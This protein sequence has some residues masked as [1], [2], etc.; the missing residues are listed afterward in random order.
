CDMDVYDVGVYDVVIVGGG[1]AGSTLA[2]HLSARSTL[3]VLLV[4]GRSRRNCCGGMLSAEGQA[5]VRE[6]GLELPDSVRMD[7]QPFCVHTYDYDN[8]LQRRYPRPYL[9]IDRECFDRW[10][11]D[12]IPKRGGFEFWEHTL[13]KGFALSEQGDLLVR[14]MRRENQAN[15]DADRRAQR[16][17]EPGAVCDAL[18]SIEVRTRFLVGADGSSSTVGRVLRA[19]MPKPEETPYYIAI[20]EWFQAEHQPTH[21]FGAIFDRS[22]S[23]YY[24]WTVPKGDQLIVGAALE[25]RPVGSESYEARFQRLLQHLRDEGYDLSKSIYREGALIR[26][27][28]RAE[29]LDRGEGHV[30]LIGEAGGWI[31]PSSSEGVSFAIRTGA[32]LAESR[33]E[34][35]GAETIRARFRKRTK[36][37]E[38]HLLRKHLKSPLM[39]TP[40]IRGLIMRTRLLSRR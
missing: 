28:T 9:N 18:R 40:W 33:L 12:R 19:R 2:R 23:D 20:Q 37:L 32:A 22:I 11:L 24:C 36:A 7:P 25:P 26:R 3:R 39:Y 14:L 17:T 35:E 15:R 29:H 10:L 1:P 21:D 5:A 6:E 8:A 38:R 34:S 13:C 31:S 27:P 30:F 4:D 16:G